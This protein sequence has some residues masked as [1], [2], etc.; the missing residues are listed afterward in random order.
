MTGSIICGVD[1]SDSA[2]GAACVARTLAGEHGLGLLFVRLVDGDV[3][4][5]DA[6]ALAERLQRLS[7]GANE[8]DCSAEW[9]VEAGHATDCLVTA[10][11]KARAE[12]IVVGSNWAAFVAARQHLRGR[13]AA[14][15]LPD[16][17]GNED[18][19]RDYA[20]GIVR[21][22]LGSSQEHADAELSVRAGT[23]SGAEAA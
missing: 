14:G 17:E 2:K 9:L 8:L 7:A 4:D 23:P 16:G 20:G 10:A 18:D 13:V 5:S 19:D 11:R 21:F 3:P 15:P 1:G 6:S 22:R 12:L